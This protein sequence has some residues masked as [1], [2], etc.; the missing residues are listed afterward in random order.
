MEL[1]G[2]AE[3]VLSGSGI[4]YQ[5]DL[6]RDLRVKPGDYPAYLVQ[7][8]HEVFLVMQP[9]GRIRNQYIDLTGAGGLQCIIDYRR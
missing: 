3:G 5:H 9:P 2:L 1:A 6:H 8:L 4:Q 7:L